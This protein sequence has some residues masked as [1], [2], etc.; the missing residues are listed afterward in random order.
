M[1]HLQGQ[2]KTHVA[3]CSAFLC[4]RAY[5]IFIYFFTNQDKPADVEQKEEVEIDVTEMV[6]QTEDGHPGVSA[7]DPE[8]KQPQENT[9]PPSE[10]QPPVSEATSPRSNL[11]PE[12]KSQS[13]LA[14]SQKTLS[15]KKEGA[16]TVQIV[17]E[18]CDDP[19]DT[20]YMPSRN[21]NESMPVLNFQVKVMTNIMHLLAESQLKLSTISS[22]MSS[23]GRRIRR[24][25][26]RN[27]SPGEQIIHICFS[28][29]AKTARNVLK[30]LC[31]CRG[32]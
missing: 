17:P 18:R 19:S 15:V 7:V 14:S 20:D 32:I 8:P 29:L 11:E 23:R 22:Y 3:F 12:E 10:T 9:N 21:R 28:A 13:A 5:H 24:P 26:R 16:S 4:F 31:F 25:A 6:S 30:A 27:F 1:R 2:I